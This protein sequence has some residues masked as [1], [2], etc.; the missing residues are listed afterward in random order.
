V[1]GT[2]LAASAGRLV[3]PVAHNAGRYWPRRGLLK[4]A[5]TI[6]VVI[7]KAVDPAGREVREVNTEIQDWIE[8]TLRSLQ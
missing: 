2:L 8:A 6:R 1:S 4:K 7:G 3:V 5:G